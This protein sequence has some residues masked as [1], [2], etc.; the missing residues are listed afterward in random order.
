MS[1]AQQ[2]GH[3]ALDRILEPTY[4][5]GLEDLPVAELRWRR[6][7]AAQEEAWLSYVRRMLHGRMDILGTDDVM[8]T[9]GDL[10]MDALIDSLSGQMG[11][12]NHVVPGPDV[13]DSPGGGRRTV[14][15]LIARSGL[16]DPRAE[17]AEQREQLLADLRAM[18]QEVSQVRAQVHAVQDALSRALAQHYRRRSAAAED[19]LRP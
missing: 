17:S 2:G 12:G 1:V 18:E 4:L 14:E 6:D 16:A 3:R 9:D 8:T 10:D 19:V 13:V 7:E 11:P 15:R 5:A